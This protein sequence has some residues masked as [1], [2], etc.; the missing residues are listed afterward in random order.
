MRRRG[1]HRSR[2]GRAVATRN[3]CL[4]LIAAT[5]RIRRRRDAA[6]K[7]RS[8]RSSRNIPAVRPVDCAVHDQSERSGYASRGHGKGCCGQSSMRSGGFHRPISFGANSA[9]T[10]PIRP[11]VRDGTTAS[12][13]EQDPGRVRSSGIRPVV[14]ASLTIWRKFRGTDSP[15]GSSNGSSRPP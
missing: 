8:V 4:A 12:L 11:S 5:L 15:R 14:E 3:L 2:E 6:T 9:P 13:P 10:R 7:R 1:R